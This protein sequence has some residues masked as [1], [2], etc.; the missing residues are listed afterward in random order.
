MFSVE[1]PILESPTLIEDERWKLVLRILASAGFQRAEQLRAMLK[2]VMAEFILH[3]ERSIRESELARE[4]LGRGGDFDPAMDNIVRSQMSHL[5][6]KLEVYFAAEG[7]HEMLRL[8]VPKGSYQPQFTE[9]ELELAPVPQTLAASSAG[10]SA[11][12][13][14]AGDLSNFLARKN[15]LIAGL[16]VACAVL[17]IA[18]VGLWVRGRSMCVKTPA[19]ADTNEFVKFLTRRGGPV[20]VVLPDHR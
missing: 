2:Y 4:V 5:R 12:A 13:A 6:R 14:P 11:V 16:S 1:M 19:S 9:I 3:P 18:V 7:R 10:A 20:L 15:W 8:S 17:A